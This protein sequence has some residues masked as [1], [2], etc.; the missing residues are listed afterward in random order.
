MDALSGALLVWFILTAMSLILAG[1]DLARNTPVSWVQKLAWLLVIAYTGP[2]GLVVFLLSCRSPG[3]DMHDAFTKPTWKQAVNSEMHCLAGDAT[4]IV[5]AAAVLSAFT[6]EW[7]WEV[8]IEYV[9][10]WIT[11]LFLFQALMMRSMFSSYGQALKRTVFV[12]TVSMNM[13]MV[14]MIPTMILLAA[15]W[16]QSTSPWHISFWFRMGLACI[17]GGLT[18]F[19]INHWLVAKGLKHG[20]MTVGM[21]H[22]KMDHSGHDMAAMDHSKMDH[23]EHAM[24]M[25]ALPPSQQALWITLTVIALAGAVGLTAWLRPLVAT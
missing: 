25:K 22:S 15:L 18:A 13:V 24:S 7:W 5:V 11:G 17:A 14:G 12:E 8:T 10:A 21:D 23:S 9:A 20:C 4:G 2:V 19:P 16:P 3:E 6:I 1:W